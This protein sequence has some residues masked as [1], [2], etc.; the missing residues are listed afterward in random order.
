MKNWYLWLQMK[1]SSYDV[2][3][4]VCGKQKLSVWWSVKFQYV[5]QIEKLEFDGGN[6]VKRL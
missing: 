4:T 6:Y 1:S 2:A 5:E 3:N